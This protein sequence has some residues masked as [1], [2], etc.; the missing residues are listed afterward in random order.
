MAAEEVRK[1]AMERMS[2]TKKRSGKGEDDTPTKRRC[3]A[4]AVVT[5]LKEKSERDKE[6][7]EN[8]NN[9]EQQRL[10]LERERHESHV[11]EHSE[12]MKTMLEMQR[13]QNQQAQTNLALLMQQQ[14]QQGQTLMALLSKLTEK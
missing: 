14:H 6:V 3:G 4:N 12:M 8:A 5:Y 7:K 1:R 2:Q 10:I 11:Q 9:L 13:Q